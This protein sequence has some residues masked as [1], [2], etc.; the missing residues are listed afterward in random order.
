MLRRQAGI[1]FM[2]TVEINLLQ[3][4]GVFKMGLLMPIYVGQVLILTLVIGE[5]EQK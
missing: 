1:L 2:Y 4:A 3:Q 5:L